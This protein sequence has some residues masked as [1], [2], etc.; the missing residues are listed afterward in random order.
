MEVYV[1]LL[2]YLNESSLKKICKNCDAMGLEASWEPL[3]HRFN[4]HVPA[5]WVRDL[6]ATT[7]A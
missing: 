1:S 2:N 4:P 7:T 3:G 5:Q 6:A